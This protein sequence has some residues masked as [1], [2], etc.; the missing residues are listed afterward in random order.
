[1]N[2]ADDDDDDD[3]V[4]IVIIMMIIINNDNTCILLTRS[5]QQMNLMQRVQMKRLRNL[6]PRKRMENIK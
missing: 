3:T 2:D 4:V 1:V 5:L 6:P